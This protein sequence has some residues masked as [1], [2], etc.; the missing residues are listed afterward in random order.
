MLLRDAVIEE[1][2]LSVT[3]EDRTAF[4]QKEADKDGRISAEQ[5]QQFYHALPDLQEQLEQRLL[6][7]RVFD[8]LSSQMNVVEKDRETFERE[9][10][11]R[12]TE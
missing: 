10:E 4:F 5:M 7:Q 8:H 1:A 6:S 12:E 3:D 11:E 2:G 9:L